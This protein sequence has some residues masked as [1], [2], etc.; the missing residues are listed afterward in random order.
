MV[1]T[2]AFALI[3]RLLFDVEKEQIPLCSAAV[4]SNRMR[5]TPVAFVHRHAL[6]HFRRRK[7]GRHPSLTDREGR[8]IPAETGVKNVCVKLD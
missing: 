1:Q 5:L 4:E 7:D 8:S 6:S 2:K 3:L